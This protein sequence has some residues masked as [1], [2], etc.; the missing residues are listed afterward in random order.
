M[1][2]ISYVLLNPTGN[3]TGLVLSSVGDPR[4]G[5]VTA[6]LMNR[7][8]QVGYLMPA[9]KPGAAARLRMMG[10]EF[11]G[12]ASMAAAAWLAQ[13]EN[14]PPEEEKEVLLEV[15]GTDE[16]VRCRVRRDG[17]GWIGSTE[18]PL[19]LQIRPF[20]FRGEELTAVRMPGMTHLIRRGTDLAREEAESLLKEA[21]A[22]FQEPAVGLLQWQ[23]ETSTLIP[24]VWVKESETLVWETACGSGAEAIA[25]WKCMERGESVEL[26]VN[27]PGGEMR[28]LAEWQDGTIARAVI[29]GKIRIEAKEI[30]LI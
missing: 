4:R 3:T 22:R 26:T 24:L 14:L 8:E 28:S 9:R 19:P 10:D 17:S 6:A 21:G 11:C 16:L 12:N 18:M 2:E 7:C 13:G 27:V 25:C 29:T 1:K 5:G 15:S 20:S 23:E 30:L